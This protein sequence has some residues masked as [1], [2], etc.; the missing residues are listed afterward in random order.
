MQF[1]GIQQCVK[2]MI[3]QRDWTNGTE[4]YLWSVYTCLL[5]KRCRGQHLNVGVLELVLCGIPGFR[6]FG[7]PDTIDFNAQMQE[8]PPDFES[9]SHLM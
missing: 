6:C 4:Y 3:A 5:C 7:N 9:G 2:V 1:I 8:T